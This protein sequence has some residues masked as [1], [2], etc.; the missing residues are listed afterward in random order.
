MPGGDWRTLVSLKN[1]SFIAFTP[2]GNWLV[3]QET[4]EGKK[5]G[6]FCVANV[7]WTA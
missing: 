4:N 3:Y 5:E 7:W 2:D 6:P 1:S